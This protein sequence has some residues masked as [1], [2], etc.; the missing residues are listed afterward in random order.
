MDSYIA[1]TWKNNVFSG[2]NLVTATDGE[3]VA[4]EVDEKIK[5]NFL[6]SIQRKNDAIRLRIGKAM[7]DGLYFI[8]KNGQP[9]R[10]MPK[11]ELDPALLDQPLYH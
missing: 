10:M 11:L 2:A 3:I 4:E 1:A 5:Q 9:L 6:E 8:N 7:I